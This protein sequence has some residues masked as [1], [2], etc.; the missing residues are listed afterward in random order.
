MRGRD[1]LLKL[2][3]SC[4]RNERCFFYQKFPCALSIYFFISTRCALFD[5]TVAILMSIF[6][7][8]AGFNCEVWQLKPGCIL[9]VVVALRISWGN[10]C[11][12]TLTLKKLPVVVEIYS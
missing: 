11:H 10:Q 6:S 12:V 4:A 8:A 1:R 7:L 9:C 5:D 3:E 2:H